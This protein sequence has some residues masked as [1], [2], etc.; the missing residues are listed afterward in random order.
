MRFL[1]AL[2]QQGL[3]DLI[4]N[5]PKLFSKKIKGKLNLLIQNGLLK[6]NLSVFSFFQ[7]LLELIEMLN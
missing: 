7:G 3:L 5:L 1:K 6:S 4:I 2:K